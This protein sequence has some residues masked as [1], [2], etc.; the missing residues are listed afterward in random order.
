MNELAD[1]NFHR[2]SR[3]QKRLGGNT[4]LTF[5]LVYRWDLYKSWPNEPPA[6]L[7]HV[8]LGGSHLF[9]GNKQIKSDLGHLLL[10]QYITCSRI[11]RW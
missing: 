6:W 7:K 5:N 9:G 1:S 8:F 2:V 11:A 10:R 3:S 4:P